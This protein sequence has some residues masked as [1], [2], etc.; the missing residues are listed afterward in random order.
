MIRFILVPGSTQHG[1]QTT[2]LKLTEFRKLLRFLLYSQPASGTAAVI[3][4]SDS[5][6]TSE[7]LSPSV[8]YRHRCTTHLT[9]LKCFHPS[10]GMK[11]I[12]PSGMIVEDYINR[13]FK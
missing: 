2:I 3:L 10:A 7:Y 9:D 1:R 12:T 11:Q 13:A 8:C 5:H 4:Q 6:G